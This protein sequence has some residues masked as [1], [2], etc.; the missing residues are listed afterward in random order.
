MNDENK[1]DGKLFALNFNE[2]LLIGIV[3]NAVREVM[4]EL[5]EDTPVLDEWLTTK[6]VCDLLHVS[7]GTIFNW[8]ATGKLETHKIGQ[9]ILFNREEILAKINKIKVHKSEGEWV[10]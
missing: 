7:K 2:E 10:H 6:E 5:K 4:A 8:R 3:K 9:R 1:K